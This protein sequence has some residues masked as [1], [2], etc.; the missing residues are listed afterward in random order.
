MR[1]RTFAPLR[2]PD[3]F[4]LWVGQ[5]VSVIGDK[6]DTIALAVL[7]YNATGSMLQMGI[8]LGVSALPSVLFGVVAGVYVDR[9]DRRR[10]MI[11][12][13]LIRAVLVLSIP[14]VV[15]FGVAWAYVVAFFVSTVSLL[16]EPA[17]RSFIVEIV[18]R[19][20]LMT[21][22]SLDNA[23]SSVSEL[24][25]L[26]FGGALIALLDV[27]TAFL[28]DSATFVVS[29]I[30][31]WSIR[32]RHSEQTAAGGAQRP[33]GLLAEA[34][35]GLRHTMESPV[36]RSLIPVYAAGAL[37]GGASITVVHA[38]ALRSFDAGA[39]G[40]A[41]L[42]AAITVGMLLGAYLVA[43]SGP[44]AAGVKFLWGLTAFGVL[45]AVLGLSSG[46]V[47]AAAILVLTGVANMWFYIPMQSIV[48]TQPA[49][50][51]RGRVI[52]VVTSLNRVLFVVGL[53]AAGALLERVG[54]TQILIGIG[55][56]GVMAALVGWSRR[57]L[58]E[59]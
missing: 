47:A 4:R 42:D 17:K 16:F 43:R 36:L 8:M 13:D 29:A 21:A 45:M 55:G 7:V 2:D 51:L 44:D 26:A 10:T 48:Q 50:Q 27:R 34:I 41:A 54:S 52:S 38:L 57:P 9:W 58:R 49:S 46:I 28:I 12:S 40:L 56:L 23:T 33:T 53:I 22:N 18:P 11:A 24:A 6:I 32:R 35:D 25:G 5:F 37:A 1:S 3:F 39:P 19:G 31:I 59:V 14:F 20:Q 30:A 15:S